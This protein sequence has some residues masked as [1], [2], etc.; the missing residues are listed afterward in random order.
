MKVIGHQTIGVDLPIGLGTRLAKGIEEEE[1]IGVVAEDGFPAV[2]A[3]HEVV[4]SPFIFQA[5][6]AGHELNLQSAIKYVNTKNRPLSDPFPNWVVEQLALSHPLGRP[7]GLCRGKSFAS[8][9]ETR[10]P[11]PASLMP[12][13]S[14][15]LARTAVLSLPLR[16]A[17]SQ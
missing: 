6:F 15:L 13:Q 2:A 14:C 17:N 4:D 7:V 8:S 3:V 12:N 10:I 5:E 9:Q 16:F 11:T 1:A